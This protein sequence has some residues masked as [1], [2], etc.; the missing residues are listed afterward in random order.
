MA[1]VRSVLSSVATDVRFGVRLLTRSPLFAIV[2]IVSLATGIAASSAIF[3]FADALLF[4]NAPGVRDTASLVDI[5]RS[6]NG[7]GDGPMAYP[8]FRFLHD[9]AHTLNGMAAAIE[10]GPLSL[11]DR[12]STDRIWGQLVSWNYFDVLGVRPS[13]GRFFRPEEDDAAIARPVVVLSSRFWRQRF[14]SDLA[15][16]G[17]TIRINRVPF[18]VIGIA[19]DGFDGTSVIAGD[20]WIPT[21]TVATALGSGF[22]EALTSPRLEWVRAIGRVSPQS[23]MLAAQSE[24]NVLLRAFRETTSEVPMS[25]GITLAHT[26]R[27]PGHNRWMGF[28]AFFGLLTML[29]TGLLMIACSNVGGML[30]ARATTRRRE[31]ATRRALGASAG[32]ILR[33]M[34]IENLILFVTAGLVALPLSAWCLAAMRSSLVGLPFP[35]HLELALSW[36]MVAFAST[37]SCAT[38]VVFGLAP[39]RL[40]LT[41]R[42]AEALHGQSS[43]ST[44]DRLRLRQLLVVGQIALSLGLLVSAGLFVRTL[45]AAAATDLGYQTRNVD[46]ITIDAALVGRTAS[47]TS[48]LADDIA[49]RLARIGGVDAV[50]YARMIPM[51]TGNLRLGRVVLPSS[52]TATAAVSGAQWD[53]VSAGYFRALNLRMLQGREFSVTDRDGQTPV[54][55]VN[56]TFAQLAFPGESAIGRRFLKA[57]GATDTGSE[58][59]IVG[60]VPTAKYQTVTEPPQPFV[61]VPFAQQPSTSLQMFVRQRSEA[62]M[63]REIRAAVASVDRDLAV[64]VQS[65][66]R[67]VG[68]GLLPQ[69]FAAWVAGGVG[70]LG[71]GLA[72]LGL[73][74]LVA[75]VVEQRRREFAIRL[76]LG[77]TPGSVRSLVRNEAVRLGVLG[78]AGGLGLALGFGRIASHLSLLL[79]VA[80]NDPAA[81]VTA[82]VIM[83]IVLLL[84]GDRPA[85]RA[86]TTNPAAAL[87]GE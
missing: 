63:A 37:I 48:E 28:A 83:G 30:L 15:I 4:R 70:T 45:R 61:Y 27:V 11:T 56:E 65:F 18:T 24:L 39:A 64:D 47:R 7:A 9:H 60:V 34:L 66:E 31:M 73:Y 12:T 53:A 68:F 81:F 35:L 49:A 19:Q 86:A 87:R 17:T 10:P 29:T 82:V 51:V 23:G 67:E 77:A 58:Y 43:T 57:N 71:I 2:A 52:G 6:T 3:E 41:T 69:R 14:A 42:L 33:Q 8:T 55:I 79:G 54:A 38:G 78:G 75:F 26:T 46:V 1:S 72:A 36:R 32:Q 21:A 22:T 50:G 84:A 16:L 85:R 80:P 25:H 20:V 40:I 62:G 74:G 44:R 5:A 59:E 13:A 76:A